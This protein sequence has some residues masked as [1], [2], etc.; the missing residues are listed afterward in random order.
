[1][2]GKHL[3]RDLNQTQANRLTL[4]PRFGENKDVVMH[5]WGIS[6]VYPRKDRV[7]ERHQPIHVANKEACKYMNPAAYS[8]HSNFEQIRSASGII[9]DVTRGGWWDLRR[10]LIP[11]NL[12][13]VVQQ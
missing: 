7:V 1:M 8:N 2:R 10:G 5:L 4:L 9:V 11:Y 12:C 3:R 13:T 6:R